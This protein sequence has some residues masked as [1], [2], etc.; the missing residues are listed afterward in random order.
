MV[1]HVAAWQ[2]P[3]QRQGVT[4]AEG[5]TTHRSLA[6]R[7]TRLQ[8][9]VE[10]QRT[11]KMWMWTQVSLVMDSLQHEIRFEGYYEPP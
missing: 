7:S 1:V 6:T 10:G 4:M 2:P 11:Q 5:A 8:A 9:G 3:E